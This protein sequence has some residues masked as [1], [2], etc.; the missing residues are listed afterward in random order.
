MST[1]DESVLATAPT[2]TVHGVTVDEPPE[3]R[4]RTRGSMVSRYTILNR[5]GAG[6]MG[7]V[8]AAYD[9]DLDR[10]VALKLLHRGESEEASLRLVREA[11]ALARLS[12]PNVVGVHEVGRDGEDVFVAME[13]VEGDTL[14]AWLRD[15][16]ASGEI[17]DVF[18][19]AAKGLDAA[20]RAGLVHRDFKPDNVMLGRDGRVRVMDFG[21]ALEVRKPAP[22]PEIAGGDRGGLEERLTGV[23]RMLGTPAFMSPEQILG[24]EVGPAADQYAFCLSLFRAL[25][26]RPAF[27]TTSFAERLE[28]MTEGALE[29][30]SEVK[31][32]PSAVQALLRR[33]LQPE[34]SARFDDMA[35]VIAVLQKAQA[36]RRRG[37]L[38][39]GA[40]AVLLSLGAVAWLPGEEVCRG[41]DLHLA[42]VWNA[43]RKASISAALESHD[44]DYVDA[45]WART[46]AAMQI[47]AD[48]WVARHTDACEATRVRGEQSEARMDLRIGC[49]SEA[50]TGLGAMT[51]VLERADAGVVASLH[52]IPDGLADLDRCD[53]VEALGIGIPTAQEADA[54]AEVRSSLATAFA[55]RWVGDYDGAMEAARQAEDLAAP[56]GFE[57]VQGEVHVML[58]SLLEIKGDYVA[59]EEHLRQ[60]REIAAATGQPPL[61]QEATIRLIYLVGYRQHRYAEALGMQDVARGLV[62]N[63]ARAEAALVTNIGLVYRAKGDNDEARAHLKEAMELY[64]RS[65][66]PE[67]PKY[68]DALRNYSVVA[69]PEEAMALNRRA[70]KITENALGPTHPDLARAHNK[71]GIRLRHAGHNEEAEAE[72]RAALTILDARDPF[73]GNVRTSLALALA[74]QKRYAEAETEART[75]LDIIIEAHGPNAE[76]VIWARHN[77]AETLRGTKKWQEAEHQQQQALDLALKVLGEAHPKV[78]ALQERLDLIRSR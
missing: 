69:D 6:G 49:L 28:A 24:E 1:D 43:D 66:G 35:A 13:F 5:I 42:R 60:A 30:P 22:P 10:R 73:A 14:T 64:E 59:A 53:D 70:L 62:R 44:A 20:H 33:G 25:Y 11:Q 52:S 2:R 40:A 19:Q 7:I 27:G 78:P 67:A 58:G 74:A 8:Y 61:L 9:P 57:P 54:V 72:Y 31:G 75:A 3:S 71:L 32:V 55:Q 47:W 18:E 15:G 34:P 17:L 45:A 36:P 48:D 56:L 16:P 38:F 51:T 65:Y 39:G 63:D 21:I 29:F 68:A 41:A 77:L 37:L 76:R 26:G 50:L 23:D 12:H 4:V 46:S